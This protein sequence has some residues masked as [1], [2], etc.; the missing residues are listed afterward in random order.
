[1]NAARVA[2]ETVVCLLCGQ[3]DCSY[4]VTGYDRVHPREQDYRYFRCRSCGLVFLHPLPALDEIPGFYPIEYQ[5][6]QMAPARNKKG[7]INRFA[8]RYYYGRESLRRSRALRALL[9][10]FSSRI[11]ADLCEAHGECRLLDVGC[12]AGG[13]MER[14]RELGWTVFGIEFSPAAS[15]ACRARGLE[16]HQGTV[17]D[18]PLAGKEFDVILLSHVIEHLPDPVGALC[19]VRECLAPGGKIIL[20][21]PNVDGI[22]FSLY[23]SCWFPLEAPRHLILF[24]PDTM[25]LLAKTASLE[26]FRIR[27]RAET[28]ML[29]ESRH[30]ARTQG[31]QLPQGL[32]ARR[33][34]LERSGPQR[35]YR[36]YR[37][38][39]SPIAKVFAW[40]GRGDTM[41]AVLGPIRGEG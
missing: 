25:R 31:Y 39:M 32:A 35:K 5:P 14:H 4:L 19:Q 24:N 3:R 12:G 2:T 8:V 1:M 13:L 17:F 36:A 10:V 28:N 9:R 22:G 15:A 21:T 41:E 29:C 40:V 38:L 26:V 16:V 37:K 33:Q 18:A 7:W 27:T 30:Y 20:K 23:R 6:H 11:M 34:I